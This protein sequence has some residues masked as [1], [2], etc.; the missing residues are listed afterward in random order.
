MPEQVLEKIKAAIYSMEK[1]RRMGYTKKYISC[2]KNRGFSVEC[3][4]MEDDVYDEDG[5]LI[6]A[7]RGMAVGFEVY[8]QEKRVDIDCCSLSY[9]SEEENMKSLEEFI[10]IY[11]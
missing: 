2:G 4:R 10:K 5:N 9:F 1:S 6:H 11:L 7:R 8:Y 3:R